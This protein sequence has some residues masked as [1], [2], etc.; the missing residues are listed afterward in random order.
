M[1]TNGNIVCYPFIRKPTIRKSARGGANLIPNVV[2]PVRDFYKDISDESRRFRVWLDTNPHI[3][4][5]V[6]WNQA[7]TVKTTTYMNVNIV[8]TNTVSVKSE[9][10]IEL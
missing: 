7:G 9:T 1:A 4:S 10:V 5:D 6:T 3:R 2:E 8:T